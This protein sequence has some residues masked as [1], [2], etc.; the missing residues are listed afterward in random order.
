MSLE[1]KMLQGSPFQ[2]FAQSKARER[3][4]DLQFMTAGADPCCA[5][6]HPTREIF[7]IAQQVKFAQQ[8]ALC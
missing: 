8:H 6:W 4:R 3:Q 1:E 5:C 2:M 7:N